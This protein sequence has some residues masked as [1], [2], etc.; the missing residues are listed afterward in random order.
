MIVSMHQPQYLPWLGFFDKIAQSDAFVFLDQVQFKP[1]EFQ[2]RNKILTQS[3]WI[4]LSVPVISKGKGRQRI[5][6]TLIDKES[7]WKGKH[8]KSLQTWYGNAEFFKPHLPFFAETYSRQWQ[9][10]AELNAHII[11]YISKELS[12]NTEIYFESQLGSSKTKTERLIELCKK[13][14]ADVYLS[15]IGG[16]DYL[17]EARFAEEGIK[18]AYQDFVHPVYRQLFAK[19]EKEFIPHM[20]I[21][22]LLFNEGKRSKEVL[23]R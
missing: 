22:D 14:R 4:W 6:D 13:L 21:L 19:D 18:L 10:L 8:L 7:D 15:G 11:R 9:K 12:I 5:C 2:N 1:R 16:R 23:R 17:D 20:C 3:S